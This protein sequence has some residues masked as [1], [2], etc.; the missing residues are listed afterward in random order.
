MLPFDVDHLLFPSYGRGAFPR[1]KLPHPSCS[2]S[3]RVSNLLGALE[4]PERQVE[5][6]G[7]W[8]GSSI[9]ADST[10]QIRVHSVFHSWPSP[11]VQFIRPR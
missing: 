1:L 3:C 4:W 2:T 10:R 7:C 6:S 9:P 11:S 5:S 8:L